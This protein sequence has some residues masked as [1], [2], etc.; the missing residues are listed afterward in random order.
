MFIRGTYA[1]GAIYYVPIYSVCSVLYLEGGGGWVADSP[2]RTLPLQLT[3][4]SHQQLSLTGPPGQLCTVLEC[5]GFQN[6]GLFTSR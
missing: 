2:P 4:G 3:D 5:S 6:L 1:V